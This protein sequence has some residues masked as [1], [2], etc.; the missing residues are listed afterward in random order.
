MFFILQN[1][2]KDENIF[3]LGKLFEIRDSNLVCC[4]KDDDKI[5]EAFF[6]GGYE[7]ILKILT[8]SLNFEKNNIHVEL[9]ECFVK[10]NIQ[11][12]NLSDFLFFFFVRPNS[13][14]N[15]DISEHFIKF[16]EAHENLS[17]SEHNWIKAKQKELN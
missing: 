8:D 16:G 9:T 7:S 2:Y 10:N 14:E 13:L 17:Q 6:I 12:L 11:T 1:E 3:P 15:I 4:R 5:S